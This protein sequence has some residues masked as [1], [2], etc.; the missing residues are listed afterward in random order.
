[1]G[2]PRPADEA[3]PLFARLQPWLVLWLLL[4]LAART[5]ADAMRQ[6]PVGDEA[7]FLDEAN[8]ISEHGGP[9]A[10][11]GVCLRGEY[12]FHGRNPLLPLLASPIIAR[13]LDA[14]FA[15]RLL[16]LGLQLVGMAALYFLTRARL[17][18]GGAA[19]FILWLA[20]AREWVFAAPTYTAEPL[21]FILFFAGWYLLS[22]LAPGGRGLGCGLLLGT[23]WLCK[24]SALLLPVAA[25]AVF[26]LWFW[27]N[28]RA[29]R[30]KARPGMARFMLLASLGFTLL[31]WP[32]LT[33]RAIARGNPLYN[34]NQA[35]LWLDDYD[36]QFP[37][38]ARG[39][40]N[41]G[42]LA[43]WRRHGTG[44]VMRRLGTGMGQQ[45]GML[46]RALNVV[47]PH[48]SGAIFLVTLLL[49]GLGWRRLP[50][51]WPRLY[52]L[53]LLSITL[54]LLAWYTLTP[55]PRLTGIIQPILVFLAVLDGREHFLRVAPLLRAGLLAAA[56]AFTPLLLLRPLAPAAFPFPVRMA[57]PP[58][59]TGALLDR[60]R[61]MRDERGHLCMQSERLFPDY[62]IVWLL[63][64]D[65]RFCTLESAAT[66]AQVNRHADQC[67]L[68]CLLL[69]PAQREAAQPAF[70]AAFAAA[71]G[72]YPALLPGWRLADQA[73]S[74]AA[75]WALYDREPREIP[76][77]SQGAAE[78]RP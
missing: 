33:D 68:D 65:P 76:P 50:A 20:L 4:L 74:P 15:A 58:P 32:V 62:Q 27:R 60:M 55:A 70:A 38:V 64:P 25:L 46:V 66:F 43:W 75:G 1:M 61:R 18:P 35:S 37:A 10:F 14:A 63:G 9:L 21:I 72:D 53:S 5:A 47:V 34:D 41:P 17:G 16:K 71:G 3:R 54:L 31:A 57:S 12:P 51:G 24:A 2:S 48:S 42:P 22:G 13:T 52:T 6:F 39:D 59:A 26:P 49:A 30:A 7:A 45:G 28:R 56:L 67:R 11:P 78:V 29:L 44:D 40:M 69:G 36:A 19:V 23:A 73:G 77:P 8:W